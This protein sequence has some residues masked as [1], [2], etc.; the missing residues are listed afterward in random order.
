VRNFPY[1]TREGSG[2]SR[3]KDSIRQ[4]G[5]DVAVCPDLSAGLRKPDALGG[6]PYRHRQGYSL[7]GDPAHACW[8]AHQRAV[9]RS[10]SVL[11]RS[12]RKGIWRGGNRVVEKR[13]TGFRIYDGQRNALH[14]LDTLTGCCDIEWQT[15]STPPKFVEC[16]I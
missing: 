6:L 4:A 13:D 2:V 11:W 1:T 14:I 7:G 10:G 9:S 16:S 8:L 5:A 3:L 12:G 15:L